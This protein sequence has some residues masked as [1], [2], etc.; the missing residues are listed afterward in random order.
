MKHTK[1]KDSVSPTDILEGHKKIVWREGNK[2][3]KDPVSWR[4]Y[5]PDVFDFLQHKVN[6]EN[7][8]YEKYG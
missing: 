2:Y 4:N 5:D 7:N 3:L 6:I 8:G 1:D